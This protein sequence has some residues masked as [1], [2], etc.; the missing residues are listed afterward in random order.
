MITTNPTIV[1]TNIPGIEFKFVPA[2]SAGAQG[3]YASG[4][5]KVG[6][7]RQFYADYHHSKLDEQGHFVPAKEISRVG[8]F[9]RKIGDFFS[10]RGQVS[11]DMVP[12]QIDLE[13]K[14]DD[15][16]FT[17][18]GNES[19]LV[20]AARWMSHTTGFV[21][22]VVPTVDQLKFVLGAEDFVR[23]MSRYPTWAGQQESEGKMD[24]VL[25]PNRIEEEVVFYGQTTPTAG[26]VIL[27]PAILQAMVE[28]EVFPQHIF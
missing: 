10:W 25:N 3:V 8:G 23:E 19:I 16:V 5:L 26:L 12:R 14:K 28:R 1:T 11:P 13:G 22:L 9:F 2:A 18:F 17:G 4:P 21:H 24:K 15:E 27:D 6:T 20:G 7:M